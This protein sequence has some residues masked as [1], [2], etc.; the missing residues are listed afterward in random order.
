LNFQYVVHYGN[1]LKFDPFTVNLSYANSKWSD[2]I[3][4]FQPPRLVIWQ[5]LPPLH[6]FSTLHV[7]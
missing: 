7:Y 5:F 4:I 6:V 1:F 2:F 3:N